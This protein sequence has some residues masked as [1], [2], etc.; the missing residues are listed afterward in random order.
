MKNIQLDLTE[1]DINIIGEALSQL[2]Y[3]KVA[4]LIYEIQKK[5][6]EYKATEVE[7]DKNQ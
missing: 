7:D 1:A 2:P 4:Q 3:Y 5:I 6:E